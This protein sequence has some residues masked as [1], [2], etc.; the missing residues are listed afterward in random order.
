MTGSVGANRPAVSVVIP[1]YNQQ[2][3]VE[4]AVRSILAQTFTDFELVAI[5][6]GSTDASLQI[7]QRLAVD[8]VRMR[9]YTQENRGRSA[10]RNRGV[11]LARA[12]LVAMM[13][14]DDISSP[15]RL[16]LQHA[17]MTA[18]PECVALGAQF[19]SVC[20]EGLTLFDSDVPLDHDTI[21]ARLLEDDGQ[22]LHQSVSMFRR[23]VCVDIGGYDI[24]YASGE[25]AD[26]FLRMAL[27][28]KLANLSDVLLRY[29]Q[30]PKSTFNTPGRPEYAL[31]LE[32]MQAAWIARGKTLPD[33]FH[34]W[35]QT[36]REVS[37]RQLMLRW[38]WNAL[39]LGEKSVARRY[40]RKLLR[41]NPF[42]LETWR[43]LFCIV[44]GY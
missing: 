38:G 29:R 44:R 27:K 19:E 35:S 33:G 40:V 18:H 10:T 26:L 42:H 34:H 13:D 15:E 21:E 5:D 17:Y 16:A 23:A 3:Y 43:L 14:P 41:Q 37:G 39:R 9:V 25:D 12:D 28:G 2:P 22:A 24:R 30:H 1:V 20:M 7:L 32:R 31:S 6:D 4:E 8:D 11:E 36:I